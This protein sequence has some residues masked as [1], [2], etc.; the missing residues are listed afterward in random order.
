MDGPETPTQASMECEGPQ[1]PVV[2]NVRWLGPA[3][4]PGKA[5]LAGVAAEVNKTLAFEEGVEVTVKQV[6]YTPIAAD[7]NLAM[8]LVSVRRGSE[9]KD[10]R[11]GREL[12]GGKVCY[13]QASGLWVG[14]VET[15]PNKAM[16]RVGLPPAE[17]PP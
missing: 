5:P 15:V 3:T 2:Q 14:L 9:T 8:A 17:P 10:V 13:Q 12:P 7:R 6:K 11:L 4:A 1:P 16:L